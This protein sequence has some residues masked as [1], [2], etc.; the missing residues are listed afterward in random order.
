[1]LSRR[2]LFAGGAL[3]SQRGGGG[4]DDEAVLRGLERVR[5]A[6]ESLRNMP[7]YAAVTAIRDKQRVFLRATHRFPERIDVGIAV[8]ERL[9]DWHIENQREMRVGRSLEG[10]FE[11]EFLMTI[12][13]LRPEFPEG[14]IG[15]PYDKQ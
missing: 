14:D 12:V 7:A 11:M 13:V 1:M 2:D 4:S 9:Q 3:F 15:I 6:V 8:W 10:R 5:T